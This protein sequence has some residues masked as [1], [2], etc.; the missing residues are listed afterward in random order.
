MEKKYQLRNPKAEDMFLMFRILSKIG[1]KN[2]RNC[3]NALAV[4]E[5]VRNAQK[6]K[7]T[8]EDADYTAVGLSVMFEIIGV[9]IEH[10][11]DA[12]EDIYAFLSRLSGIEAGNIAELDMPDFADLLIEVVQL[13]GFRDFFMRVFKLFK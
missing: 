9:I 4:K 2:I 10:T 7:E 3:F 12:K 6:E 8:G 1:I 11:D 5:A 13:E